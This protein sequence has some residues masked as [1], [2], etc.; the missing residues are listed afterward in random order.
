MG[1]IS[2][3]GEKEDR[4]SEVLEYSRARQEEEWKKNEEERIA[5]WLKDL[6]DDD[7]LAH[8]N[9][10]ELLKLIISQY[11]ALSEKYKLILDSGELPSGCD[12]VCLWKDFSID[13][14]D[15]HIQSFHVMP[16]I[17]EK[18]LQT[19]IGRIFK[20]TGTVDASEYLEIIAGNQEYRK[21]FVE[22]FDPTW[23]GRHFYHLLQYV[24]KGNEK[25]VDDFFEVY[26]KFTIILNLY[27]YQAFRPRDNGWMGQLEAELNAIADIKAQYSMHTH[28]VLNPASLQNPLYRK[29]EPEP[30]IAPVEQVE[31][32]KAESMIPDEPVTVPKSGL[33]RT[34]FRSLVEEHGIANYVKACQ[35]L[36]KC[37]MPENTREN[38]NSL[39]ERMPILQDAIDKFDNVYHADIDQFDEYFAPEALKVTATL[40]EYEVVKPSE[41]VL[42]NTRENVYQASKK[43]LLLVNE[44][45]DEIYK[46]VTIE[47]NAEARALEALMSQDGYVDPEFKLRRD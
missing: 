24:G 18:H 35:M 5:S 28:I 42:Q 30:I 22:C 16:E 9:L 6:T 47:T 29:E 23:T 4:Y 27:F 8:L 15:R 13:I 12:S 33:D 7:K 43:L 44:K 26:K 3:H 41:E 46:F 11:G 10:Q 19:F 38:Y 37:E 31:P 17:R 2:Y 45:I 36:L 40:V 25:A 1:F 21:Y 34:R 39:V 20:L 14:A 32:E